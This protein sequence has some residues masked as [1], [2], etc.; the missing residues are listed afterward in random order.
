MAVNQSHTENRRGVV[1]P[2]GESLLKQSPNVELS[3]PRQS[4]GSNV[5]SGTKTGTLFLT[6]YR[7]IFITSRSIN[8]P[9]L[10]F[11]MPFDLITN[12][13][14]EQPVFAANFIKGTIQAAPYGGWE[15]QA[16]FKLVFR[17]GGAIEFAQLMVKAA[18]SA[19]RGFPLRTLNDWFSSMRIY[20]ITGEGNI[21]T[22]QMPCSVIAYGAPPAGYGAPPPGYGAPPAGYGA[23]P[24]GNEGLPVGY[25]ASPAGYGAPPPGYGAPPAGYGAQPAG[26]EGLPVG[27]RAS[28]AGYGA[29]PLGYEAPPAGNEGPPAGYRA[30]PAGSGARPHESAAAQAPENEA[31]LPS[32]SSS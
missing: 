22:P 8:D 1:I 13:T 30:S 16:T 23:Q 12:L 9:M 17:N 19:A 26:N 7:V 15:G 27:Y 14:V 28:P 2:N 29:P 3:F 10:S 11:M 21:C 5:F 32:A 6:S 24:A 20:V 4:E 31:S 25:R 18:S